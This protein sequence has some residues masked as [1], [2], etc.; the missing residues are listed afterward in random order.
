[1]H[2]RVVRAGDGEGKEITIGAP[3]VPPMPPLPPGGPH[4]MRLDG[5]LAKSKGTTTALGTKEFDGVKAEGKSI[6]HTIP[7]GEIG[8][9]SA[10]LVTTETWYS[11]EL[12]VTV[13]SRTSD[14]RYGETLYRLANIR[15][16]EPAADLFK[17]PED[18]AVSGKRAK[19]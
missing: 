13:F 19:G 12:Q 17:V 10:I 1:V 16:G 14:P 7:A 9:K 3:P 18:Y 2:V 6:L 4:V 5:A 11:P 8:N 15:R